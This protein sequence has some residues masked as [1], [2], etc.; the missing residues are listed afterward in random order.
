MPQMLKLGLALSGGGF[1]A[2]LYHLGLIRF[3]R[4][5]GAL[6]SVTDIA[7]VSG[8]SILAAHLVLNWDRYNGDETSFSEATS[9]IVKFAQFDLRNHIVRRLPLQMPFRMLAKL[10]FLD[11]RDYT[12][13]ALL[14]KYYKKHLYGD[15]CLHELPEQPMLHILATSISTGALS[16]FNRNGLF[17]QQRANDGGR[18]FMLVPGQLASISRVVGASSAFPGFFPPVQITAADMGVRDGQFPTDYFTDGGVF[19]NL[20]LR[21][22][23]WLQQQGQEFDHVLVSDAGKPFQIL[24]DATLGFIGQSVRASDILWDRVWQLERENF[25]QLEGFSFLPITEAVK[26]SEDPTALHAVVQSEVQSIRTDLDRFS[27]KEIN[28]LAQHGYEVARKVCRE[29]N[30]LGNGQLPDGPPWAP[31]SSQ[32]AT[33]P[34]ANASSRLRISP[35]TQLARQLRKSSRRR[36]WSTLLNWRDW[37]SYVYLAIAFLLLFFVPLQVYQI[38]RKSQVQGEIIDA[39]SK[40]DPDIRQILELA[41]T[42]PTSDWVSA[43]VHEKPE[44]AEVSYEGLEIL[45]NSRIYDLRHWHP[46]EESPERRGHVYIRDRIKLKFLDSYDGNRIVR[47]VVPLR[48]NNLEFRWPNPELPGTI[49]RITG[50]GDQES[51]TPALYEFEYDLS[52]VLPEEPITIEVE[53]IG[54]VPK[55]VRAPFVTHA[56]TD[57]ISAWMLFPA[58]QPYR[59]YS[60]VSYPADKSGHPQIMNSRYQIDH[61][62]GSLIGWSVVNPDED[63]VYECRWTTE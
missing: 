3:L 37:P 25:G 29:R 49:N 11:G 54:D 47:F 17:L 32:G 46:D 4:D 28:V 12:P 26:R 61:P 40:G 34:A 41:R 5:A 48:L 57:L 42:D 33:H 1:R 23:L 19:D 18:S 39:I 52:Q 51:E 24:S 8:G 55:T 7:S 22:F 2:T 43:Q 53:L 20:G 27:S 62:Y 36:V 15:R 59:T 60:L 56:K 38:Y 16:A 10:P 50:S 13:N 44:P 6:Q 21:A 30:L 58:D 35:E 63:R 45:S 9:E 14:E 31:I